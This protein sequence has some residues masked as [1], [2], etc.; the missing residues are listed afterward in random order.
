MAFES[1]TDDRI[2]DLLNCSKSLINPQAG[3]KNKDGYEQV[4][5]K[6]VALDNP[7]HEF[8]IYKRQSLRVG[9]WTIKFCVLLSNCTR[10][11]KS[12]RL[13][14]ELELQTC[15]RIYKN[16]FAL[17]ITPK[18]SCILHFYGSKLLCGFLFFST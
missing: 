12:G 18:S 9:S 1:L 14:S 4:N 7:G 17:N 8:E 11:N 3:S 13:F 6:A 5:F 10:H 15:S 2:A 16:N